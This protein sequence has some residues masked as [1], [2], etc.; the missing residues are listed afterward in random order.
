[1]ADVDLRSAL[2]VMAGGALGCL[3][4]YLAGM[5]LTRGEYPWGTLAVNLL[6]SFLIA[7]LMF[8]PF[9]RGNLPDGARILLATGIL[10]GFTTM[11]SFA[12]ETLWIGEKSF[13]RAAGYA[14]LTFAGSLGMAWLG[15]ALAR[16]W[17]AA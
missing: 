15:R 12:F 10:G 7:V 2:L 4:R 3:L 5:W 6:G 1:M 17:P 9:E 13:A 16:A 14:T 11:S 8:G